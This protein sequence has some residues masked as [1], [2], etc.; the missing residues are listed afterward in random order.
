M[1]AVASGDEVAFDLVCGT[2]PQIG[3]AWPSPW[4]IVQCD[5]LGFVHRH[6]PCALS[7]VH[8][9]ASQFRLAVHRHRT[10]DQ[11]LEV[12]APKFAI[13]GE[14]HTLVR[15]RLAL[16]PLGGTR[17]FQ[18]V[19]RTLFE[20]ASANAAQDVLGRALLEDDSV[21]ICTMQ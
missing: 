15:E 8:E 20:H 9:V 21:D 18:D 2:L 11:R 1:V 17:Q 16:Q 4:H 3:D 12:D 5:R 10:A 19:D 14:V 7:C 6:R 13:T